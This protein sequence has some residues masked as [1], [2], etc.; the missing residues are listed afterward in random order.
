MNVQSGLMKSF[1]HSV[2][3]LIP[4]GCRLAEA[5]AFYT[6]QMGFSIVW[7][8]DTMAGIERDGIAFNLVE[9]DNR[10]WAENA[11]FSIGVSDLD[12]LY[13]EYRGIA[14]KVGTLEIKAW[15]RREFHLITPSGVAFQFYQ[16]EAV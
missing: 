1:L 13:E 6:E 15:G 12:A 14:A 16:R 2:T 11:S 3:P 7:Q 8:G 5:I 4:S 10:Q 9:N